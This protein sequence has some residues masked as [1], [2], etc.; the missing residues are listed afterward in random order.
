MRQW[1]QDRKRITLW[2]RAKGVDVSM[3]LRDDD[4][5]FSRKTSFPMMT[6]NS[7]VFLYL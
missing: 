1:P 7:P 2:G 4:S 6:F 3:E 5:M